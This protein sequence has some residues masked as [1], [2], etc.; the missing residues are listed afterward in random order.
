MKGEF[1]F[2]RFISA[3]ACLAV[4][5]AVL[6]QSATPSPAG[7]KP[8]LGKAIEVKGLVTVSDEFGVSRVVLN[9]AVID[10]SRFVTSSSGWATLRLNNGCEIV[11]KPNQAVTIEH[12]KPCD[13]LWASL[14]SL[15][16]PPGL[17]LAGSAEPLV[18]FALGAAVIL[19]ND[20]H[21]GNILA[22]GGNNPGGGNTPGGGG[23]TPG[24]GGNT[25]GGGGN[26]PGGGTDP[27]GGGSIPTGPILSPQ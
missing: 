6:A 13:A 1:M 27:G 10:R 7:G 16:T 21:G 19:L 5:G 3:L 12:E 9:N 4:T 24:G 18:P 25:P 22:G 8:I 17:V 2:T 11:L 20:G 14:E 15:G 23:N 26:T